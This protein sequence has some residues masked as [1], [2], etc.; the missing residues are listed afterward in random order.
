MKNILITYG[1]D[2]FKESLRRIRKQASNTNFFDQIICYS[3]KDLPL[4][5][6]ASS[7][8][9][10]TRGGG[11]WIWKPWIIIDALRKS[12]EGDIIWYVDAGCSLNPKVE[13]WNNLKDLSRKHN[14]IFFQYRDIDYGWGKNFPSIESCYVKPSIC[15]WM[16]P[17]TINYFE[18]YGDDGFKLYNKIMAGFIIVQRGALGLIEEWLSISLFHPELIMDPVGN[19][20]LF[21]PKTFVAHRHDQ[22]IIT[23]LVYFNKEKYN[24]L[25]LPE[26]S[27]S[28]KEIAAVRADRVRQEKL[29]GMLWVK[30]KI[31]HLLYGYK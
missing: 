15:H 14:A 10:F 23:P 26:T 13:E 25:V 8:M 9:A 4:F 20:K 5:I 29:K 12:K 19:E 16:K 30:T 3:P 2:A 7:L 18:K 28:Q 6:T 31:Y 24:I 22:S 27:E 1:D 11:Y 21:L 17:N